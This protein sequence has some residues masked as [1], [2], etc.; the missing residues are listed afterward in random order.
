MKTVV[1]ISCGSAKQKIPC[2]AKDLYVGCLFK[3]AKQFAE[4]S[5][6]EWGILSALHG[7]IMPSQLLNPY[8]KTLPVDGSQ[9][10][11]DWV[12]STN[13]A[14]KK[15]WPNCFFVCLAPHRYSECL[16]GLPAKFPLRG[17]VIFERM[18]FLTRNNL[19]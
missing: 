8:N 12:F 18:K 3:K 9:E 13:V 6:C 14:I 15:R 10:Y 16:K 5:K 19:T 1:L 2:K 4:R 7:L 11:L 17:M